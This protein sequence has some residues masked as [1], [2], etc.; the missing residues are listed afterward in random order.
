MK[1]L[2]FI[3]SIFIILTAFI[4]VSKQ[5]VA[6]DKISLDLPAFLN[7]VQKGNLG[8]IAEQLNI[9]LSEA[10]LEASKIF[11]D[12]EISLMYSNNQD[13][14]LQ[15]GQ[16]FETGLSYPVNLGNRR[17]ASITL[18]TSLLELQQL[19]VEAYFKNLRADAS[20]GFYASLKDLKTFELEN[21]I[22]QQFYKLAQSDS[23]RLAFGEANSI[24]AM[25]SNLEAK[26]QLNQVFQSEAEMRNSL[27][28]LAYLTGKSNVNVN[29]LPAGEFPVSGKEYSLSAL[30][31]SALQNRTDLMLA[32]KNK[33]VSEKN[34]ELLYANRAF[35]F[36]VEAGYSYNTLVRNEIAPAPKHNSYSAGLT[37]PLKFSN[38]NKGQVNA[39]K[40]LVSQN[41]A[42]Y[43][44]IQLQI[45]TE[46]TRA[47]YNYTAIK[48]QVEHYNTGLTEMAEKI[49]NGR[50]FSYQR[51]ETGLVDVL[52]A[53]KTYTSLRKDF[54][55]IQYEYVLS[56]I[57]LQHAAGIWEF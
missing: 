43:S 14:K 19:V 12:P 33:E 53:Q 54:L 11:P 26:S 7:E 1:R 20:K 38:L 25:Q 4:F 13:K 36:S 40:L 49:L 31:D 41:E 47:F 48:K 10:E 35:E 21:E 23:L 29:F 24:D 6:Q 34:V 39:A 15:M 27:A 56:L 37:I 5:T 44:D 51:G 32:I 18:S 17:K 16:S 3:H 2:Y 9:S 45:T 42:I 50:I 28:N 22:Y 55:N 57:E 8:Y 52:N 46:V 30:I